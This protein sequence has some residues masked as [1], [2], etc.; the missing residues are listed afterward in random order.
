ML[1]TRV[2]SLGVL[3]DKNS[4]DVVI[5]RLVPFYRNTWSDVGEQREGSTEGEVEGDVTL[6]DGSGERTLESDG[7]FTD[8]LDCVGGNGS[9]AVDK[10]GGDIDLF[11]LDW[12]LV[13][14][15]ATR[16][17]K[18]KVCRQQCTLWG[19]AQSSVGVS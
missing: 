2:L 17:P 18:V 3:T 13:L 19:P 5:G 14:S 15:V 11:P 12:R 10:D 6:A 16:S 4:V 1:N 9:F 8:R 7:V